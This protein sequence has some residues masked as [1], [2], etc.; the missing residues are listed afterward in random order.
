MTASLAR[1]PTAAHGARRALVAS[2]GL[3]AFRVRGVLWTLCLLGVLVLPSRAHASD[4]TEDLIARRARVMQRLGPDAMLILW[5]APVQR[6]SLDIDYEYRQDSNLYYLT[7]VAQEGAILVL[8]PGNASR[9]EILFVK[10][11][12]PVQEH[13]RGRR[14]TSEEARAR[15]G[16]GTVLPT[17]QFEPFVNA[18][19]GRQGHGSISPAEAGR[20]VDAVAAGRARLAIVNDNGRASADAPAPAPRFAA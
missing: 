5:S 6:Y 10:D 16:I 18:M 17:S 12:D 3:D 11:P 2:V 7:G 9:R 1:R 8:M 4:F 19:A 20:F 13:W 14:M 15:T